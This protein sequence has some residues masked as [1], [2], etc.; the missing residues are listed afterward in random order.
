MLQ[1]LNIN[2]ILCFNHI[3]FLLRFSM[4]FF[5]FVLSILFVIVHI[6]FSGNRSRPTTQSGSSAIKES[7]DSNNATIDDVNDTER[8]DRI[9]KW[10][11]NDQFMTI[12]FL[13]IFFNI[14]E[15]ILSE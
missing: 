11:I 12:E 3:F 15:S 5:T 1:K 7:A 10:T 8:V 9:S 2:V 6:A 13:I 14:N 4:Q